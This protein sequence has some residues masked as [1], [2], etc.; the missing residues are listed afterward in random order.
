[1]ATTPVDPAVMAAMQPYFSEMF[2]NAASKNHAFGREASD[3]VE[4]ARAQVAGLIGAAPGEIVFT[5]GATESDNL[6]VKGVA[7]HQDGS[8]HHI[9]TLTTEHKAVLDPCASMHG[10]GFDVTYLEVGESGLVDLHLLERAITDR[11]ILV[12]VMHANNEIGVIQDV[13][14]IGALCR[15]RGIS[16]HV[17]GAQSVG[18]IPV[19]VK[20]LNID[21][22]SISG[23]KI[24]APKGIGALYVRRGKPTLRLQ[25]QIDGGGHERGLRSGTLPVPLI[26]GLGEACE[27][28]GREM[29]TEGIR[30]GA[31]RDRLVAELQ[32]G[33]DGVGLNGDAATRLPGNANLSFG[34]V[35]A[36][37]LLQELP[38]I[39]LSTGSACTT[40]NLEPSHVLRA[41]GLDH[42]TSLSSV[43]FGLG[44]FTTEEEVATTIQDVMAAVKRLR[45][46]S[47]LR[48]LL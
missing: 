6:A 45:D 42:E 40:A 8:G 1:H 36:E 46:K 38:H 20:G 5:S 26:V 2:G 34:Q 7:Q 43:R 24:Y 16:F 12:S 31:L 11:T 17:D 30:L 22:L 13:G 37:A 15:R 23:H 3:A 18:K 19:D 39:A 14:E 25:P 9:I 32:S 21:L 27:I 4:Q 33:L 44:R 29:K 28:S 41:L 48:D 10:D 47:L 35:D